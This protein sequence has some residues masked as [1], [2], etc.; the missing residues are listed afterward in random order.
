MNS[1]RVLWRADLG[2][3]AS[4]RTGPSAEAEAEAEAMASSAEREGKTRSCDTNFQSL[5]GA[6]FF[7]D[8]VNCLCV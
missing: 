6:R 5:K 2:S 3:L 4:M 1:E 7:S 8:A